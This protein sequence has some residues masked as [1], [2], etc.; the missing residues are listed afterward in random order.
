VIT[1]RYD[2]GYTLSQRCHR[3]YD[4]T[5]A[6]IAHGY[7]RVR[8][9]DLTGHPPVELMTQR[10]ETQLGGRSPSLQLDPRRHMK[11]LHGRNR[12]RCSEA[13]LPWPA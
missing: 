5:P 7:G 10:G 11:R 12:E 2:F 6:G 1:C 4:V 8:W 9:D 3:L 13:V